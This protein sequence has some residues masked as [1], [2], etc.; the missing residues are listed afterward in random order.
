MNVSSTPAI[1]RDRLNGVPNGQ[2]TV[3]IFASDHL[4]TDLD[5]PPGGSRP[6]IDGD[7]LSVQPDGSLR[8]RP[9]GTAGPWEVADKVGSALAYR[10]TNKA[11]YLLPLA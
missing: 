11:A 7:V 4:V 8:G 10:P 5:T 3:T 1:G 9:N 6:C 2:V